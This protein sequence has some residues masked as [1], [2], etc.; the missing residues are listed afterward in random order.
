MTARL[1]FPLSFRTGSLASSTLPFFREAGLLSSRH[2]D[3]FI[4]FCLFSF[5]IDAHGLSLVVARGTYTLVAEHRLLIAVS[6]LTA[7]HGL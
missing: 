3:V 4:Y 1:Y 2:V 7:E 6:S 5:F